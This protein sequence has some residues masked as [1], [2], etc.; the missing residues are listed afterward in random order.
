MNF[1]VNDHRTGFDLSLDSGVFTNGEV[2]CRL[3]VSINFTVH[4]QIMLKFDGSFDFYV[5]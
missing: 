5:G 3:D 2:S 1:S 4:D